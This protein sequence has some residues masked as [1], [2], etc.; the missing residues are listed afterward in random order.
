VNA[1]APAKVHSVLGASSA[2]RWWACP[3]SVNACK[4]LENKSTV[5]AN[6]GS[7]AHALGEHCLRNQH[8]PDRYLDQW[9]SVDGQFGN[10]ADGSGPPEKERG[11]TSFYIDED[12]VEA[13][14]VYVEFFFST[15]EEG[16]D[17]EIEQRID[18][19]KFHPGLFG[20]ADLVIY[21]PTTRKLIV[22]DYKHGRG[23]PVEVQENVQGLYYAAGAATRHHN[24][25]LAEVEVVIIQPR[26]AHKDGPVRRWSTSPMELMEWVA[27]LV[28]AAKATEDPAA[29]RH[30]GDHCKFCPAAPT[31]PAF[32]KAAVDAAGAEFADTGEVVLDVPTTLPPDALAQALQNVDLI[33]TW[34]KAVKKFAHDEA[35]AGRV[36][37]GFKLVNTRATR[38]WK[39]AEKTLAKFE[40]L[41]LDTSEY[42]SEPEL[43]SVAQVEKKV[44]KKAFTKFAEM[45]ESK[46]SGVTLAPL[47]DKR[48]AVRPEAAAEFA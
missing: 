36:P 46:S 5:Y 3:G 1:T 25:G 18:L 31:C 32:A 16:D 34:C 6:E 47:D 33:E 35:I 45:V 26:C 13:V 29:P 20:T 41:E 8:H 37:P 12:M 19:Q 42:L 21:K 10:D 22:A 28:E 30:A 40:L 43:L 48:E 27:D 11:V 2:K 23:V 17:Y 39:D 9:I 4:G 44:G 14:A 15:Y 24:R 7:A 38:R